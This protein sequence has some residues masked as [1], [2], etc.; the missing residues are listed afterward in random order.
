MF[1]INI[2]PLRQHKFLEQYAYLLFGQFVI[3]HN[4]HGTN[5]VH[6]VFDNPQRV[7]FNPKD[8]EH[9]RRYSR[10]INTAKEH[11]HIA[12][13]PESAVPRPWREY[14]ECSQCKRSLVEPLGWVLA[15][16]TKSP[17]RWPNTCFSRLFCSSFW[18]L[19]CVNEFECGF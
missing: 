11:N 16:S 17:E 12:F 8:C 19:L 3:P 2:N 15:Y 10:A 14:L 1:A 5:E 13:T 4:Q 18:K 7:A 6:L 9:K